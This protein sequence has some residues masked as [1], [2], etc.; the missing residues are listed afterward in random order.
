M[1]TYEECCKQA[2]YDRSAYTKQPVVRSQYYAYDAGKS[3]LCDSLEQ[4]KVISPIVQK[5][6][7]EDDLKA[8]SEFWAEQAK[9]ERVAIAIWDLALKEEFDYLPIAIFDLCYGEAYYHGHS[10]GHDSVYEKMESLVE[11]AEKI[12]AT[13]K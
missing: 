9:L 13:A 7:N 6:V 11:F 1:K 5:V 4:A 8:H 3:V 12:L 10:D 2:G